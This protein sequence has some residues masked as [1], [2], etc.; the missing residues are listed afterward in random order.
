VIYVAILLKRA[1]VFVL[2]VVKEMPVNVAYMT[3]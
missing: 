3:L 2:I 1:C